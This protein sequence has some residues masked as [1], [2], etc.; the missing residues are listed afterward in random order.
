M[1]DINRD[2][3]APASLHLPDVGDSHTDAAEYGG[4]GLSDL[5]T[6]REYGIGADDR[7]FVRRRLLEP[8]KGLSHANDLFECR[9][10]V[11]VLP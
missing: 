7:D 9:C 5:E 8:A 1:S 10:H 3:L 6:R 4:T 11:P 2:F